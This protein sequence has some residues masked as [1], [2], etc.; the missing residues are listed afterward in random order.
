MTTTEAKPDKDDAKPPAK[1]AVVSL[2]LDALEREGEIAGPFTFQNEGHT[3]TMIDPQEIDWQ[4]LVSAMRNP[5]LFVR[6]ALSLADQKVFF[7]QRVPGWKMNKLMEAYVAH[8]G[9]PDLGNAS[10]L[11]T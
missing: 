7:A 1:T 9:L 8:F 3:F 5:A 4:D 10:A 2:D 6:Y 11:R